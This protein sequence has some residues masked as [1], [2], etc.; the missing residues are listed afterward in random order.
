MALAELRDVVKRYNG[1]LALDHVNIAVNKGE[2]L[3]LLGPNGAGKTTSI[4]IMTTLATADSGEVLL[5]GEPL[6]G[7]ARLQKQRM[8]IVPQELAIFDLLSARENIEY[9]GRLYGLSGAALCAGIDEALRFVGLTDTGK[10]PAGKFSGGMKRRL[11]IGCAIVHRPE[12]IIMDEPTV[13]I[14][15]QSRNHILEFVRQYSRQGATIIY[16]SHYMEEV[17]RLCS[18]ICIMDTGRI[19]AEGSVEELIAR[20]AHEERTELS[21]REITPGLVEALKA[22][23]GVTDVVVSGHRLR[24][25]AQS[26]D[27]T[28][29]RILEIALPYEVTGVTSMQPNLEDV[30]LKL[31]G[32]RLRDEGEASA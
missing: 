32:K 18:R 21:L 10:K 9:F 30:F 2:I 5:F 28:I 13:G 16:T 12:L 15:P 24:I 6:R 14:D 26:G 20:I 3:G 29:G 19:I 8:G 31:T 11:N 23:H 27:Q 1:Q 17:E 7:S 4:R 22:V 25:S